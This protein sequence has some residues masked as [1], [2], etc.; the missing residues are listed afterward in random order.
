MSGGGPGGG[1]V[2]VGGDLAVVG[3]LSV[4]GG[5][6]G[7]EARIDDMQIARHLFSVASEDLGQVLAACFWLE[8]SLARTD[9]FEDFAGRVIAQESLNSA[10]SRINGLDDQ[11]ASLAF[12]LKM[13]I[14]DYSNADGG[15]L[16]T[17]GSVV[18]AVRKL[19]GAYMEGA[20]AALHGHF[21]DG[22]QILLTRDP[23]LTDLGLLALG[24]FNPTGGFPPLTE[25]VEDYFD[26]GEP[27]VA[28]RSNLRVEA[29][30]PPR[31]VA[32]LITSLDSLNHG[33]DGE[34][35]VRI[36]TDPDGTRHVVVDIPGTKDWSL[37]HENPD[38]TGVATNIRALN[39]EQTTYEKGVLEAMKRAG[40][41][42]TD[43]VM[44]VGHSLGGMIAVTLARDAVRSGQFNVTHVVTAGAPIGKFVKEV[45]DTV[46]VLALENKHDVVP[47]LDGEDNPAPANVTTARFDYYDGS[48]GG[49]HGIETA[50]A[51][52]AAEVDASSDPSIRSFLT[53]AGGY[54]DATNVQAHS[55]VVTRTK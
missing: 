55:Y 49:A 5:S 13:A 18:T 43:Q 10:R 52:A 28:D 33:E 53:S 44:V 27:S 47:R 48:V 41:R 4:H 38:V 15:V 37:R 50:Y 20:G 36:L 8:R 12:I 45:P 23:E 22:V 11:A 3:E 24:P 2:I 9:L 17:L 51:P 54:F 32:D 35:G 14:A 1:G 46:Q 7:I 30:A 26:D 25:A 16:H 31:G 19:P 39:G 34:V 6:G 40:V 29:T 21:G 42:P